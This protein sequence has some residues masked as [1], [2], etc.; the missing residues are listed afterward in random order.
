MQTTYDLSG[1]AIRAYLPDGTYCEMYGDG[2]QIA[3]EYE[4]DSYGVSITRAE[5]QMAYYAGPKPGASRLDQI[6]VALWRPIDGLLGEIVV[7]GDRDELDRI[8][9]A[10]ARDDAEERDH[11]F[12][13]DHADL[14]RDY[15]AEAQ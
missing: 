11:L 5:V 6:P 14:A 7:D 4:A 1:H 13:D 12:R 2:M 10:A 3:I 8:I 15:R 9:D